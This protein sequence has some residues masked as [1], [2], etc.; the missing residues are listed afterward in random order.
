MKPRHLLSLLDITKEEL[1]DILAL[2]VRLKQ[3]RS[4]PLETRHLAGKTVA[5]IFSKSSTRTRVSF[6][7]GIYELGG[8]PMFLDRDDLQLGRGESMS[9]TAK[10]LNRYVHGV[11]IRA[12]KH[13]SVAEYAQHSSIPVIN[14]LTDQF[15]P[16][17]LVADLLTILEHKGTLEGVKVAYIG[18]GANNMANSWIIAAKMAGIHLRVG[19]PSEF[20]PQNDILKAAI[21]NGSINLTD[22][23]VEAISGA[24]IVYTDVWVSMGFENESS[25]RVKKLTPYQVNQNL[26]AHADKHVRIMHCLPAHRGQEI[27]AEVLDGPA[28][29]IWDQA[30]NRLHAQ[31]AILARLIGSPK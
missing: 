13:S 25:E 8:N 17:Q 26:I 9:D 30:E 16:C 2:A 31:K 3:E 20:Q 21:G 6:H 27:S 24:D 10:V 5:L 29:I 19:A 15:H 7:A 23:P 12:H 4:E 28:S 1:D 22:D 14:G 11:A 18:D